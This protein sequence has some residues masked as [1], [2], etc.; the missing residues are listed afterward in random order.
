[1][2]RKLLHFTL[3]WLSFFSLNSQV[4]KINIVEHFTNTSCS[5]CGANNGSI[6]NSVQSSNNVIY[7]S[8]HPSAPYADDVFNV[9]NKTENDD[10]TKWYGQYGSTPRTIVNGVFQPYSTLT[11]KLSSISSDLSNFQ[12]SLTQRNY[13]TDSFEVK[14]VVRKVNQ[15]THKF[16]S[17][18]LGVIEDTINQTTKN[19]EKSHYNVFRKALTT[20]S[21]DSI[22]ISAFNGDSLVIWRY[23][24]ADLA[25]VNK[26]L[27]TVGILQAGNKEVLNS[28]LA[29]KSTV[30]N[31]NS[32]S[33]SSF[34]PS[35]FKSVFPNPTDGLLNL[36]FSA[37]EDVTV[38]TLEGRRILYFT[39]SKIINQQIQIQGLPSGIYLLEIN[40]EGSKGVY[41]V[42]IH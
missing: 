17:V 39:K 22:P 9:T 28:T 27:N 18:F 12:L 25:W 36:P 40:A 16:V 1:M 15:D 26:R 37:I 24:K 33:I 7:V 2:C 3:S 35:S 13:K 20:V 5:I 19:G 31:S 30:S 42:Q 32:S 8:Y 41:R 34:D 23:Y 4:Q 38:S 21:G 11:G 14:L 6:L 10:R 29:V